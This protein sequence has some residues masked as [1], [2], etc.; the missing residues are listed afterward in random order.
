MIGP[1]T[2]RP[3]QD[4]RH[5]AARI[6][7]TKRRT[8]PGSAPVSKPRGSSLPP[9]LAR[10]AGCQQGGAC[11]SAG[12]NYALSMALASA[13]AARLAAGASAAGAVG[14]G[15][16]IVGCSGASS[17]TQ[18]PTPTDARPSDV[19]ERDGARKDAGVKEGGR[20]DVREAGDGA[21]VH[22]DGSAH[23]DASAYSDAHG[24][25]DADAYSDAHGH[26][27]ADAYSDAHGYGD[28]D[29]EPANTF[30]G[31]LWINP[32][33]CGLGEIGATFRGIPAYCQPSSA[34]GFYQCDG[35]RTDSC[36]THS[37]TPTSTMS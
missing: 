26:G 30:D 21:H 23:S 3:I 28:A 4:G 17:G 33:T 27:D 19:Q 16:L 36:A 10:V 34:I 11:A 2:A 22:A 32:G 12:L 25:S 35:S 20:R 7:V 24:H 9:P 1:G 37:S 8:G 31:A 29:A 6:P 15:V 14:F 5:D 13:F 18:T